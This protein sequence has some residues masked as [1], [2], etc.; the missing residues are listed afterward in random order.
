VPGSRAQILDAWLACDAV[1]LGTYR[2]VDSTLG[3]WYHVV[4]VE[5]VWTGTPARGRL[6]FKAP[7]GVRGAPGDRTLLFLW[8]RLA[9]VSDSFLEESKTRHGAEVWERIGP[10]SLASYLLPFPAWSYPAT[11]DKLLLRG[12]GPFPTEIDFGKLESECLE[13]EMALQPENLAKKVDVVVRARVEKSDIVPRYEHGFVVERRV[14]S[15]LHLLEA[16][17]GQ[18]PDTL[19]LQFLSVPRSPRLRQGDDLI[20]FL[21][22]GPQALYLEHGKRAVFHVERGEVVEAGRPL[23]EFVKAVRG[24]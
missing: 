13:Y 17:K 11:K 7:R 10:D 22:R 9:G 23:A 8:D 21:V 24:F 15:T 14:V 1:V 18:A 6:V 3:R 16:L 2:G 20:L 4:D 19:Q 12:T 5:D